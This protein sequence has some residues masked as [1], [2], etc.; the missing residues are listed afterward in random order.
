LSARVDRRKQDDLHVSESPPGFAC[1]EAFCVTRHPHLDSLFAIVLN[2]IVQMNLQMR[3]ET[4]LKL[5]RHANEATVLGQT[6]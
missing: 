1:V 5:N 2:D 4:L 3:R 6:A